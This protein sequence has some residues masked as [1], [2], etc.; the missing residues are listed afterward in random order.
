MAA[1]RL[2][3]HLQSLV[4]ALDS[5]EEE[6]GTSRFPPYVSASFLA[7]VPEPLDPVTIFQMAAVP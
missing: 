6:R 4:Q 3:P 1:W 7:H 2:Q 5:E